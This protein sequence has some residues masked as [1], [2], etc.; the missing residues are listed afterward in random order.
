MIEL[1]QRVH[2]T[3]V[4]NRIEMHGDEHVIA[5]DIK[6]EVKVSNDMLAEFHPTL[7]SFL[8][9]HDEN[10]QQN[11]L[12]LSSGDRITKLR[13]PLLAPLHWGWEA[14][15]YQLFVAY[16]ISRNSGVLLNDCTVD[17]FVFEPQEG[18]TVSIR[19]RVIAKPREDDIGK[20]VS[21]IGQENEIELT[22]PTPDQQAD[23]LIAKTKKSANAGAEIE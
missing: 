15:G 7:K 14:T 5:T 19:C 3:H 2:I 10:P 9:E 21:L 13:F 8:F 4:G 16:G 18:G 17:R 6:I 11:E 12:D 1:N 20:L 23:M 22:P